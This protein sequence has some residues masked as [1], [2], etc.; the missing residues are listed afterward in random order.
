[1]AKGHARGLEGEDH[2]SL[3]EL[4]AEVPGVAPHEPAYSEIFAFQLQWIAQDSGHPE[5]AID[6][7]VIEMRVC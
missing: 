5:H 7:V 3:A 6:S 2:V 1:V 4:F